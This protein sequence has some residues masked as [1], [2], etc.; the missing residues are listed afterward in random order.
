MPRFRAIHLI[1]NRFHHGK[2]QSSKQTDFHPTFGPPQTSSGRAVI[3]HM[4]INSAAGGLKLTCFSVSSAAVA[5]VGRKDRASCLP[6]EAAPM[7]ACGWLLSSFV[8]RW[9]M[10]TSTLQQ[11][12]ESVA[13]S[14]SGSLF[15]RISNSCSS[16]EG[17][18]SN[19]S[20]TLGGF[21]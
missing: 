11:F 13:S 12:L 18:L 20:K 21:T 7:C 17:N 10:S 14:Y 6:S 1:L 16:R 2:A 3:L 15:C 8:V 4:K 19:S 5:T 9:L